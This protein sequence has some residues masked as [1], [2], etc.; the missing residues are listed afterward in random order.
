MKANIVKK[1][2]V[3]T[4]LLGLITVGILFVLNSILPGFW[5]VLERGSQSEIQ[6]YIRGFGTARGAMLAF[7]LQFMQI[8]SILFPG[9]PI[10]LATGLVF[11]TFHGFLICYAGY[12]S[13]NAVVFLL[14]RKLG[15]GMSLLFPTTGR[16]TGKLRFISESSSPAFM[17]VLAS[18]IPIMPNGLVPY[19]ASKTKISFL[20][21]MVAVGV[22]CIPCLLVLNAMGSELLGGDYLT[23]LL[24]ATALTV[25][26]FIIYRF[27]K[28][29]TGLYASWR[30]AHTRKNNSGGSSL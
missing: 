2:L 18:L 29:I 28:P 8:I 16:K 25:F 3:I 6:S 1:Y 26:I 5:G 7:L 21:Y 11:G 17:V 20:R 13:A 22:G 19:I 24:Y 4:L 14:A 10:Q 15:D 27:H 23:V 9:V 12:V 30:Q